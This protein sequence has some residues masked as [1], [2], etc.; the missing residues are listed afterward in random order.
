MSLEE[1]KKELLSNLEKELTHETGKMI[2]EFEDQAKRKY[3]VYSIEYRVL[4]IK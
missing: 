1:A 2:K 4:R 3:R